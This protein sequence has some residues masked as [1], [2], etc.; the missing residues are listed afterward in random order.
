MCSVRNGMLAPSLAPGGKVI[1]TRRPT[2]GISAIVLYRSGDAA[3]QSFRPDSNVKGDAI[4]VG[5]GGTGV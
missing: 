2:S 4:V 5:G 3:Q 1:S